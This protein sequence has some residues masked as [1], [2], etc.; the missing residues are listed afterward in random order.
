MK[1]LCMARWL[2]FELLAAVLPRQEELPLQAVRF[3]LLLETERDPPFL[4]I[5]L[6][7]CLYVFVNSEDNH[8]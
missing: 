6:I 4:T 8:N 3:M 7:S 2:H 5:V 1:F